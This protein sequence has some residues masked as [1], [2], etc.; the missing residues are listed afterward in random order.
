MKIFRYEN[1][2]VKKKNLLIVSIVRHWNR[3]AKI[4][5]EILLIGGF[6]ESVKKTP[7]EMIQYGRS[8][9]IYQDQVERNIR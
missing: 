2:D 3:F 7:F 6:L 5:Y 9:R 1:L 4:N 8:G